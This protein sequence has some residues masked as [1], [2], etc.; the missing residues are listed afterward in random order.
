MPHNNDGNS[1][2]ILI[3]SD[4]ASL[5][6]AIEMG[7]N[8]NMG[9]TIHKWHESG[10]HDNASSGLD[11]IIIAVSSS[12]MEPITLIAKASLKSHMGEIPILVV[13][14]RPFN[15]DLDNLIYHHDFPFNSA[16]FRDRVLDLL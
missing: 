2:H 11:L 8:G 13:S 15:S 10:D 5:S 12:E 3:V 14:N 4:N 6:K 1:K 16:L 9:I 7:L